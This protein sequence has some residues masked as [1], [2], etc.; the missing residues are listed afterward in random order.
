MAKKD[1][2]TR[3]LKF[4]KQDVP[5]DKLATVHWETLVALGGL[6]AVGL[7]KEPLFALVSVLAYGKIAYDSFTSPPKK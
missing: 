6:A 7:T 4:V 5:D 1:I 2:I 3:Y